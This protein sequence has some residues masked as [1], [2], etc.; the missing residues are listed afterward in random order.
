MKLNDYKRQTVAGL[1]IDTEALVE[2][3]RQLHSKAVF[4]ICAKMFGQ[5]KK[6]K[7]NFSTENQAR[8]RTVFSTSSH[9]CQ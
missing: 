9:N 8:R 2:R 3:G 5:D 4:E 7:T 1:H 6:S